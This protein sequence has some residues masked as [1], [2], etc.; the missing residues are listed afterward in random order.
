MEER[1]TERHWLRLTM[2]RAAR[3][4]KTRVNRKSKALDVGVAGAAVGAM[5]L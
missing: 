3:W 4:R 2:S 5:E 1:E